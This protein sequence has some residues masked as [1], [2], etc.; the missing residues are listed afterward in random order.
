MLAMDVC[1]LARTTG[2]TAEWIGTGNEVLYVCVNV[3]P[4]YRCLR[5]YS[6]VSS[7]KST[8]ES[9]PTS[10]NHVSIREVPTQLLFQLYCIIS[11]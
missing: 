8:T 7:N 11:Q 5:P 1:T 6:I 4:C 10:H 2:M 9:T 3:F